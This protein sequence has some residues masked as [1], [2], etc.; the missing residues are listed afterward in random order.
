MAVCQAWRML[1]EHLARYHTI[2]NEEKS[3]QAAN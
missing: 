1:R 2:V 3:N